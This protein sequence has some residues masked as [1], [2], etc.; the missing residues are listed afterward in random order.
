[1]SMARNYTFDFMRGCAALLVCIGHFYDWNQNYNIIPSSFILAVD[2]FLV[3]SGFVI[4]QSIFS[5]KKFNPFYFAM[6]RWIRLFPVFILCYILIAIPKILI[7]EKYTPPNI[8]DLIQVLIIGKM[9]PINLGTNYVDPLSISYTIS[10]ELWVGIIIFPVLFLLK[11]KFKYILLLLVIAYT[12]FLMIH[13]SPNYMNVHSILLYNYLYFGVIRCFL[14]YS[15]GILCFLT[16]QKLKFKKNKTIILLT[17]FTL[18]T[19]VLIYKDINYNKNLEYLAPLLFSFL[20]FLVA[21]IENIKNPYICFTFKKFGEFSYPIYLIHP[22]LIGAFNYLKISPN[23]YSS[24]VFITICMIISLMIH[25]H[26]EKPLMNFM[27][28]K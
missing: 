5:K 10:A 3:L 27:I 28:K 20:I 15:L 8:I 26:Y 21:H 2:F 23:I 11:N 4:S 17:F 18:T 14:D 22:L 1:M 6:N 9:L 16:Y 7:L 25:K 13:Y 19:I 12:Y 24:M